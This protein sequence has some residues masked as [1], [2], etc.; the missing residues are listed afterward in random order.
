[1]EC[2]WSTYSCQPILFGLVWYTGVNICTFFLGGSPF[3]PV[4][5][6]F[7]F[8]FCFVLRHFCKNLFLFADTDDKMV[9]LAIFYLGIVVEGICK[10]NYHTMGRFFG[11]FF[12]LNESNIRW[13]ITK[14]LF[15]G[16]GGAFN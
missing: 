12:L 4:L 1:M 14:R 16:R 15:G 6:S 3:I 8:F 9:K 2:F 7:L 10:E 11:W 13:R 5:S